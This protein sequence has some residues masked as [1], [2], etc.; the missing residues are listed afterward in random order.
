MILG[1]GVMT[2]AIGVGFT[3][4]I[5][6]VTEK[7][8]SATLAKTTTGETTAILYVQRDAKD[9][10]NKA[11]HVHIVLMDFGEISVKVTVLNTVEDTYATK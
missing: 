11:A 3:A 10:V 4:K 7:Q 5:I 1:I 6:S 8:G 9:R 2:V